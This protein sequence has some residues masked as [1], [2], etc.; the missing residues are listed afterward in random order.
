[1]TAHADL[2]IRRYQPAD[3][4]ALYDIC[5]RT[6]D[7]GNDATGQ[8]ESPTLLGDIYVGPYVEFEPE[9]ARVLAR[10]D[11]PVG[12]V[13]GTTDSTRFFDRC[14]REWIDPMLERQPELTRPPLARRADDLRPP[15]HAELLIDYPAHL[16]IDLLPDA[17]GGGW[18]RRLITA[19]LAEVWRRQI[20]G[21]HLG[22][23][24]NNVRAIGFYGHVGFVEL[25]RDD[26]AVTFGMR[27]PQTDRST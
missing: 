16:H 11:T 2:H 5:L 8:Y 25:Q 7:S 17:Q 6:G 4:D 19:W 15:Q 13:I 27:R 20:A 3:R 22:V 26:L 14:A 21:V 18:G 23:G 12:Y 10:N 9:L 1:M 24:R